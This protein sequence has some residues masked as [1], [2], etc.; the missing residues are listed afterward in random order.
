M[1]NKFFLSSRGWSFCGAAVLLFSGCA[2]QFN[3]DENSQPSFPAPVITNVIYPQQLVVTGN[4]FDSLLSIVTVDGQQIPGF[5][6]QNNGSTQ[7]LS[8]TSQYRPAGDGNNPLPVTVTVKGKTSNIF[9]ILFYPEIFS[10]STDTA[11]QNKPLT[12]TGSFF[13]KRTVPSSLKAYYI[14]GNARKTY[15]SPDPTVNAWSPTA[16]NL[17]VPNYDAFTFGRN[18]INFYIQVNVETDTTNQVLMYLK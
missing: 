10:Y 16:I 1:E 5:R 12:V 18:L 4:N 6:Y 11:Q 15:M 17:T 7:V 14:D 8:N 2:K 13:G 3:V 9:P